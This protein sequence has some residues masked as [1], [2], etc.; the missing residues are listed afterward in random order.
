MLNLSKV[1]YESVVCSHLVLSNKSPDGV[2]GV[3]VP[4]GGAVVMLA[5][6]AGRVG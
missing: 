3:V 6:V 4:G 2:P 1:D 5:K